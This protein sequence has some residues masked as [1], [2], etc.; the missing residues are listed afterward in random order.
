GQTGWVGNTGATYPNCAGE[1]YY[2]TLAND[3]RGLCT[4]ILEQYA[5]QLAAI[6]HVGV[7]PN[8]HNGRTYSVMA[9]LNNGDW[10][11]M[12]SSGRSHEGEA[13]PSGGPL[14]GTYNSW[15]G[16]GCYANP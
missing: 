8:F 10:Y 14:Q 5:S 1:T 13:H 3:F 7:H 4:G 6:F 12:G 15:G 11:C 9:R 16:P 2:G